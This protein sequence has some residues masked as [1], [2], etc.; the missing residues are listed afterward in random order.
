MGA[1]TV[2]DLGAIPPRPADCN[3]PVS[4]PGCGGGT[5]VSIGSAAKADT[6]NG[7]PAVSFGVTNGVVT[8]PTTLSLGLVDPGDMLPIVEGAPTAALG[9]PYT[10]SVN[11]TNFGASERSNSPIRVAFV[12]PFRA[13]YDVQGEEE[14]S[15]LASTAPGATLARAVSFTP[16]ISG[17]W[18]ILVSFIPAGDVCCSTNAFTVDV[19]GAVSVSVPSTSVAVVPI[20][21]TARTAV[22]VHSDA[23]LAGATLRITTA[24]QATGG[25][26]RPS[27]DPGKAVLGGLSQ[28]LVKAE[29]TSVPLGD[30]AAG[31]D[32]WSNV[33]VTAR[34]SG[35]YNVVPYVIAGG[36][37][38]TGATLPT[39]AG[40]PPPTSDTQSSA[41]P[42]FTPQFTVA[43]DATK[44]PL[45]L[46]WAPA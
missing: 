6:T 21:E 1:S 38:Y 13:R 35:V 10:A 23:P 20:G 31:A 40:A 19:P 32:V 12:P 2:L 29:P 9:K 16:L 43:F 5:F 37:A 28:T 27:P 44:V 26:D 15:F 18:E 34:A 24:P 22:R 7:P 4:K 45:A 41:P 25:R 3:G 17:R 30:L 11:V 42:A 14:T 39:G 8:S 36:Y 33:T 46:A